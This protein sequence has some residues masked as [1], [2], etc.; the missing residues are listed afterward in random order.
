MSIVKTIGGDRLG[1]SGKMKVAMHG[2]QRSTHN[3]SRVWRSS[4]APGVLVPCFC[5]I[6]L[7]GDTFN[8][9][10]N[11]MIRT[12]PTSA[13]LF[14]S[15]KL[16]IDFFKADMRLYN[17]VLHNNQFNIGMNMKNVY[18][19]KVNMK[20]QWQQAT[21]NDNQEYLLSQVNPSSLA[22][23]LGISGIASNHDQ[24]PE[25]TIDVERNVN[26]IPMLAYYDIFK[27]YYAN[28][29][30]KNAYVIA[31][32]IKTN[33]SAFPST[34]YE[35]ATIG[36]NLLNSTTETYPD[37][38][39]YRNE[40][41]DEYCTLGIG[42]YMV[43]KT[44]A[45]PG[46]NPQI[47]IKTSK[48]TLTSKEAPGQPN[49]LTADTWNYNGFYYIRVKT[50]TSTNTAQGDARFGIINIPTSIKMLNYVGSDDI[51]IQSFP[52]ANFDKMRELL[53][54]P[55][56]TGL[57]KELIINES[58]LQNDDCEYPYKLFGC[59]NEI[60]LKNN[61]YYA[62]SGLM[63]KTYQSDIN[64]CW[65]SSETVAQVNGIAEVAVTNGSFS[66]DSLNLA[67]KVYNMLNRIAVSGG[68][69]YDW[70]EVVWGEKVR[71]AIETPIYIG[72]TSSEVVFEEVVS[73]SD[74]DTR[75]AG[76]QPLG[77]LAGKGK[78]ASKKNGS[79]KVKC[80]EP[81][82]IMGI[83]S[84]TPRIDYAFGNK[85]YMTELNSMDDLHKPALDGIGWQD[86]LAERQ[87]WTGTH[88]DAQ[89]NLIKDAIGKQPAWL[90]YMTA[91]NE[92]HGDFADNRK[93]GYMVLKK[94]YFGVNNPYSSYINPTLYN[95]AFAISD[96]YAQNFWLQIAVDCIARRKI[97]AKQI[98]NL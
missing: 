97:S 71:G 72:G 20:T 43:I 1:Q 19:P 6:G 54:N 82:V 29:Q 81:C 24:D 51:A 17:S 64:T 4:L 7:N 79:I 32:G 91:V 66:I 12:L 18:L 2:Y 37:A 74:T 60:T 84:I 95:Y 34:I 65:V 16:Q 80:N 76:Q 40:G 83:V 3:L 70:Q 86:L 68:S 9:D 49:K 25:T 27:N 58:F 67:Q 98:P 62:M 30:E 28:K 22:H 31:P 14:G 8:I 26:A 96:V 11:E 52:L 10:L 21:A 5:E 13:P 35:I 33:G 41:G 88:M 73:T 92:I 44:T 42:G 75:S 93:A 94:E 36:G 55:S 77:S 89:G 57:G 46:T 90:N 78:L 87:C 63:L 56:N 23:Y 45:N 47:E 85:W 39:W 38:Q 15:F 50:S 61:A 48:G 59:Q 53:L 69:Y